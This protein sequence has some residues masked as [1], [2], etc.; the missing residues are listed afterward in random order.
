MGEVSQ[1]ERILKGKP[2][3]NTAVGRPRRRKE[4][5]M[6]IQGVTVRI[7]YT[8]A[9]CCEDG[10]EPSSSINGFVEQ[11]SVAVTF[12]ACILEVCG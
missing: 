12:R 11:V 2:V 6:K 8:L 7:A 9:C 5:N 3:G 4:D 1:A 10:N